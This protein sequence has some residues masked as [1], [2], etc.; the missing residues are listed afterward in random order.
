MLYHARFF[1]LIGMNLDTRP[2]EPIPFDLPEDATYADLLD[3]IDARFS[4]R[5]PPNV[6]DAV[7]R[8]FHFQVL[9][10]QDA[11]QF[12]TRD[13]SAPL[14]ENGVMAFFVPIAGG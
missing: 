3:A 9:A 14:T 13:R 10:F 7:E 6:W 12:R 2:G 4:R 5:F 11:R 8:S 1:G